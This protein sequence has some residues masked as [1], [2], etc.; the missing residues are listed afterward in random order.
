M[1]LKSKRGRIQSLLSRVYSS[2]AHLSDQQ[3]LLAGQAGEHGA[4]DAG[5]GVGDVHVARVDYEKK[6]KKKKKK[7]KKKKKKKRRRRGAEK[8]WSFE[9]VSSFER[10]LRR[11]ERG[12]RRKKK[13][14]QAHFLC[15]KN[16]E[17]R[18]LLLNPFDLV[19]FLALRS[20]T[21]TIVTRQSIRPNERELEGPPP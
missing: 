21:L 19:A 12:E 1:H 3:N 7:R 10:V 4:V 18:A 14:G 5:L 17:R 2:H 6:K 8:R 15:K 16:R 11:V 13:M 20:S 9:R